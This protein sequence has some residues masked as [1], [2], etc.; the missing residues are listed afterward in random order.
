MTA[1]VRREQGR[2]AD[3]IGIGWTDGIMRALAVAARFVAVNVMILLGAVIGLGLFGLMPAVVAGAAVLRGDGSAQG[4][5]L[6]AYATQYRAQFVRANLAGIPF[7]VT[8]ALLAA[9]LTLLTRLA[10]PFSAVLL[11]LTIAVAA[12][13]LLV[14]VMTVALLSRHDDAPIAVLRAALL[15]TAASPAAGLGLLVVLAAWVVITAVAPILLPLVGVSIP[16]ALVIR[17]IEARLE[18]LARSDEH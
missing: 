2:D 16:L 15:L 11:V 3:G 14:W 5:L 12:F 9:D 7:T 4:G 17:L 8:G 18:R 1:I 6:R 10:G 13:A